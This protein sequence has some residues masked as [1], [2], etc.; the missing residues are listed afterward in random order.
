MLARRINLRPVMVRPFSAKLGLGGSFPANV[1][2]VNESADDQ[3]T[4]EQ[5]PDR[6]IEYVNSAHDPLCARPFMLGMPGTELAALR[7]R[8]KGHWGDIS[9]D[10]QVTFF[11]FIKVYG[12]HLKN[13]LDTKRRVCSNAED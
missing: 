5:N 7:E 2:T 4:V 9:I 6:N 12:V 8:E 11:S 1:H 3:F 13:L 10:D